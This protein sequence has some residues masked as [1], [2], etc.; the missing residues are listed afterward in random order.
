MRHDKNRTP[1]FHT[2]SSPTGSWEQTVPGE[3]KRNQVNNFKV[4]R[5]LHRYTGHL[6]VH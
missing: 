3:S 2:L 4:A 6:V 1:L 5:R